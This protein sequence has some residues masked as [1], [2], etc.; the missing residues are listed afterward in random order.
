MRWLSF[1]KLVKEL[2]SFSVHPHVISISLLG[3]AYL[4]LFPNWGMEGGPP[5]TTQESLEW[6]LHTAN[7]SI[8][9]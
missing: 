8:V 4:N 7:R 6:G 3:G 5:Q 2:P 9:L 1:T